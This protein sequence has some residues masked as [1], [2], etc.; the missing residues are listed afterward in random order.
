MLT[1]LIKNL[2]VKEDPFR[3]ITVKNVAVCGK[4][5]NIY[6]CNDRNVVDPQYFS[7]YRFRQKASDLDLLRELKGD[8]KQFLRR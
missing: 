8:K 3:F 2:Q 6:C 4:I 1:C 5:K 7:T